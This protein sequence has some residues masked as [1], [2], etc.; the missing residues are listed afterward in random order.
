[1]LEEAMSPP[2]TTASLP[3]CL[4]VNF[5]CPLLMLDDDRKIVENS[6]TK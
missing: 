4:Y 6:F 5:R 3:A 2:P 1:M